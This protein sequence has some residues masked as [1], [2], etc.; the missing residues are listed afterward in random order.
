LAIAIVKYI[1][2]IF[3]KG[4]LMKKILI[5]SL[6]VTSLAASA[7]TQEDW[8]VESDNTDPVV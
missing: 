7:Y 5:A 3:F 1:D 6:I 8:I 2:L 4:L